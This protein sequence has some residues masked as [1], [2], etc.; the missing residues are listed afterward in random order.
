[1]FLTLASDYKTFTK[2]LTT[3]VFTIYHLVLESDNPKQQFGIWSDEILTET[4]S[5]NDF[6]KNFI[7]K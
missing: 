6:T 7:K 1:M 3:D 2:I 5:E 4:Q